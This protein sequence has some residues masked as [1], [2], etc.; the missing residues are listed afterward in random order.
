MLTGIGLLIGL[1]I[2]IA[3]MIYLIAKLKVHAFIAIMLVSIILA[4]LSIPI[5]DVANTIRDGFGG[6]LRYIG[7]V[8]ILGALIG[9]IVEKTGAALTIADSVVK[10]VG[11]KRPELAMLIM[12]WI[13]SI[14]VFCDSGFIILDP[15][16]KSIGKVTKKSSVSLAIALSLGLYAAHVFV[17]PTP[18]PIAAAASVGLADNL[19]LVMGVGALVSVFALVPSYFFALYIGK[20]V[21]LEEEADDLDANPNA[22]QEAYDALKASYGKLPSA[23]LSFAPIVVP[24]IFLAM[25]TVAR[26]LDWGS[27]PFW[28]FVGDPIIALSIGLIFGVMLLHVT[29]RMGEFSNITNENLKIVGPILFITAAGGVLGRVIADAGVVAYVTDNADALKVLGILFPFMIATILKIAQGSSTVAIVTTAALMGLYSDAGSVMTALGFTTPIAAA[30]V[31]MAIGAGA[32]T[33]SHAN[34]SYF[35]VVTNMTG[36]TPEQGY[37]TQTLGTLVA[38]VSSIIGILLLSL[39]L[40]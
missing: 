2:G 9:I 26:V 33:V 14:P 40:I 18:G 24:I 23:W 25:G 20:K 37:K 34:D 31:V 16:R 36:M 6:T 1:L 19:L 35:W 27:L 7:L 38:G 11:K 39:F 32:M 17:P 29:N 28:Q 4:L 8:I 5:G 12:G 30:L 3:A 13:V 10:L 22:A 21:V 15:I